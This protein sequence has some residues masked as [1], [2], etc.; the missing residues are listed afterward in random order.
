MEQTFIDKKITWARA[1]ECCGAG[2][3]EGF[4][5]D[6]LYSYTFCSESCMN[7]YLGEDVAL[8]MQEEDT[9]FWTQWDES[10]HEFFEDTNGK[11]H[12]IN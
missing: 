5:T 6:D 10:E 11:L 4:L 8:V 12:L 1:C 7:E 3:N 9:V 2:M